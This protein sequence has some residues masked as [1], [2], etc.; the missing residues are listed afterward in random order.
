[1]LNKLPIVVLS[2]VCLLSSVCCSEKNKATPNM[3]LSPSAE[4]SLAQVFD[5]YIVPTQA[6]TLRAARNVFQVK[7][8]TSRSNSISLTEVKPEGQVVKQGEV[9]A[10]F[11]FSYQQA[12]FYIEDDIRRAEA[13]EQKSLLELKETLRNLKAEQEKLRLAADRAQVDTLKGSAVSRRQLRRYQIDYQLAQ[14]ELKAIREQI[15]IFEK[16][17]V[18]EAQYHHEQKQRALAERERYERYQERYM[19]KAPHPGIVR[20]AYNP[21]QRRKIKKGDGIDSGRPVIL[22]AKDDRLSVRFFVP[23]QNLHY[24]SMGNEVLVTSLSGDIAHHA[25]IRDI[26]QFPQEIGFLKEDDLLANARE[27]AFVVVADFKGQA[28]DFSSGNEVKVT[29]SK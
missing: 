7:G 17:M 1:M 22:I 5:G 14:F 18:A 24:L 6:S 10:Q 21:E 9:I 19:L 25:V 4:A 26:G 8:W 20:H 15:S 2:S 13:D 12:L 23:E 11:N 3:P 29:L 28:H 16:M 27:K